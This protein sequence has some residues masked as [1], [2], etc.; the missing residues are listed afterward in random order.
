MRRMIVNPTGNILIA[1]TF[2]RPRR[3]SG[4]PVTRVGVFPRIF[5]ARCES[6]A[7]RTLVLLMRGLPVQ[8][9]LGH[10]P[11]IRLLLIRWQHLAA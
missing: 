2:L 1:C 5:I 10:D 4:A 9:F 3:S 6:G 7:G 11:R 8:A